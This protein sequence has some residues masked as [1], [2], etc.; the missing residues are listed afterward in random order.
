[1]ERRRHTRVRKRVACRI[2]IDGGVYSGIVLDISEFG[3]FVQ[4]TASPK[5]GKAVE[6]EISP[7]DRDQKLVVAARIA[8][9]RQVP[10]QL[11]TVAHGG[12]GLH[13]E[14]PTEEFLAFVQDIQP[15]LRGEARE[16]G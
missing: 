5:I 10:R 9:R 15:H 8:R 3:L 6:V 14:N 13:V 12:V 11:L 16:A 4:T 7:P 1:M 2:R